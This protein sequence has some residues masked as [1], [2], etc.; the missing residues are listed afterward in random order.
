VGNAHHFGHSLNEA[1]F[2]FLVLCFLGFCARERLRS[3]SG[4][5]ATIVGRYYCAV[6]R[7]SKCDLRR[8][9]TRL[10]EQFVESLGQAVRGAE[11]VVVLVA[12]RA[13]KKPESYPPPTP[14]AGGWGGKGDKLM[15]AVAAMVDEGGSREAE[16][17]IYPRDIAMI[18]DSS[19]RSA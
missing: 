11:D 8:G 7:R 5:H 12:V 16:S 4:E 17:S 9:L 1:S 3:I 13:E 15:I 10:A 18:E 6:R 14:P 19:W 2:F